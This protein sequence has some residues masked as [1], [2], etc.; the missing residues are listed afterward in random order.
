MASATDRERGAHGS[1]PPEVELHLVRLACELP[2]RLGRSLSQWDCTELAR[3]LVRDGIVASISPQG[4]RRMRAGRR[5]K[6][7]RSHLW[8]H[9]RA[10]RDAEFLQ[11]TREIADLLTRELSPQEVVLSLDE[12]TSLQPRPRLAPTRPARPGRPVQVE[13]EYE[14]KGAVHLFAAFDTRS[15]QVYGECFSRKRQAE[16]VT[17]LEQ[18]DGAIPEGTTT[19]HLLCD[20]V[21]VHHGRKVRRWLAKHPRFVLHFTPVHCS[22]MNPV[23][24]WF[25]ILRRKR[26]RDPNFADVPALARAIRQ[27]IREWNEIAHPFDWTTKSFEQILATA[28]AGVPDAA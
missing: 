11:R 14:R 25:S 19:I 22:W 16:L 15:G 12:M 24:Q 17:L 13:H 28:D 5:L 23:E 7:W 4:V 20:N 6:P 1:F 21:S 10:P 8:L 2:D 27:F 9:P 18:L 3:Q 26:L